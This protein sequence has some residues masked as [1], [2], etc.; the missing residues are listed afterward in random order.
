[1]VFSFGSESVCCWPSTHVTVVDL[2]SRSVRGLPVVE[3]QKNRYELDDMPMTCAASW[4]ATLTKSSSMAGDA[5]P[6]S[7]SSI[8]SRQKL[9]APAVGRSHWSKLH[10]T[11]TAS[12]EGPQKRA[13]GWPDTYSTRSVSETPLTTCSA[14]TRVNSE[15]PQNSRLA[16]S[17]EE[18]TSLS[19]TGTTLRAWDQNIPMR[20]RTSFSMKSIWAPFS[21]FRCSSSASV[22]KKIR[23]GWNKLSVSTTSACIVK[24]VSLAFALS[25]LFPIPLPL[26][27]SLSPSESVGASPSPLLASMSPLEAVGTSPSPLLESLV[28]IGAS[29]WSSPSFAASFSS[30]AALLPPR[31]SLSLSILMRSYG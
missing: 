26:L 5:E 2:K 28:S 12:V 9:T 8:C 27:A 1:M 25:L 18:M 19:L 23:M 7:F 10:A 22:S 4:I 14:G 31:R 20:G 15:S 21:M 16:S 30:L 29:P 3:F 6:S 13:E 17:F 24:E 11:A